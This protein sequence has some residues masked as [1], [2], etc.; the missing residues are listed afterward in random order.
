MKLIVL[1]VTCLVT[2]ACI[3]GHDPPAPP[4]PGEFTETELTFSHGP[5]DLVGTLRLP[6]SRGAAPGRRPPV[7]QRPPGPRRSDDRVHPGL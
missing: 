1:L 2:P 3:A 6:A 7:R 5:I 4:D